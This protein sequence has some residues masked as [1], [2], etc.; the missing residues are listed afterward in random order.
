MPIRTIIVDDD[1]K[2]CQN[3]K[4]L[5]EGHCPELE[6]LGE[7]HSIKE[8]AKLIK[9]EIPQ[10]IFLDMR[11]GSE[12]G[13]ELFD[14]VDLTNCKVIVASAYEEFAVDA[15][16]FSAVDYLLKPINAGRLRD[17]VKKAKDEIENQGNEKSGY[18]SLIYELQEIKKSTSIPNRISIPTI[19]GSVFLDY[20]SIIRCEAD[21]NYTRIFMKD[22]K[23]VMSSKNLSDI[24]SILPES[25]FQ[26]VHHSHIINLN[27]MVEYHKGKQGFVVM[28][29]EAKIPISQNKKSSFLDRLS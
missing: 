14:H 8:A 1:F 25:L 16:E 3:M 19:F 7:A 9:K 6:Y 18:Q 10:L 11:M 27:F 4:F 21:R 20:T 28:S 26:R 13:F 2:A 17:A 15:F 24:Q 22:N 29:D 12:R 5:I 23:T